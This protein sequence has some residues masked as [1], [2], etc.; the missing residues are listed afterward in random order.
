MPHFWGTM[1]STARGRSKAP[2]W[3]S[4]VSKVFIQSTS[5]IHVP[6]QG[7]LKCPINPVTARQCCDVTDR[8]MAFAYFCVGKM[9]EPLQI[10]R[11][12]EISH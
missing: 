3:Q 7:K 11:D 5:V 9:L 8:M 1:S 12:P 6:Q 4:T 2:Q 10:S